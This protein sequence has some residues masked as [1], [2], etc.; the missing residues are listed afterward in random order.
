MI[1]GVLQFPDGFIWGSAT[2]AYQIEGAFNEDDRGESIWDRFSHTPGKVINNDTGDVACDHYH[3]FA[4]DVDI[5]GE[6][7]LKAYRFSISW[8]R[9][10]PQGTGE[11]N[12][13]GLAFYDRLVDSLIE[14]KIT[15]FVTF[16]HWDLPQVLE[17]KGG[18]RNK[19]I[20]YAFAEYVKI[21]VECLSDRVTNWMTLNEAPCIANLGYKV[22]Y[23]APGAKEPPKVVN[24]VI[25]NLLLAHGLGVQVVRKYAKKHP[26][27]GLVHNPEVKIPGT[28]SPEDILAAKTAW[29]KSNAWWFEPLYKGKY[30]ETLWR[31]QGK[32]IPEALRRGCRSP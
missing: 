12:E 23:H 20:A 13:K 24:Q 14:K 7:G 16:Y 8:P 5:M 15:P 28:C 10:L 18:W 30:P 9:I 4:E 21:V 25:H 6:I 11:I 17:D 1:E 27:V 31:E 32:N 26:E 2:A 22:G 19:D 29:F 3:R